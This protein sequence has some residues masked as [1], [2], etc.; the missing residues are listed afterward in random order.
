MNRFMIGQFGH[1]DDDKYKRDFKDDFYG[2]EACLLK[3]NTDIQ[4]LITAAN[5]DR[6]NIGIHY[7]LRA[8]GMRLRDPQLLSKDDV[9]REKS[10]EYIEDE[11]ENY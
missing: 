5:K 6:F 3:D 7:P 4:K 2:I 9:V 10:F 1:Y 11:F 8:G